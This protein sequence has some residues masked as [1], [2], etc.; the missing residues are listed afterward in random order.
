MGVVYLYR[1]E[2]VGV[3]SI[4]PIWFEGRG[5]EERLQL[6]ITCSK[7]DSAVLTNTQIVMDF[8]LLLPTFPPD[9]DRS[10]Q[11]NL[12]PEACWPLQGYTGQSTPGHSSSIVRSISAWSSGAKK[13][14]NESFHRSGSFDHCSLQQV[15]WFLLIRCLACFKIFMYPT[16]QVLDHEQGI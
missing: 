8:I 2:V 7:L 10:N 3:P 13:S 15:E 6:F 14:L 4:V 11:W 5:Q 12:V 1:N 16:I 9:T